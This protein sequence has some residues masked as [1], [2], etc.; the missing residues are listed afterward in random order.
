MLCKGVCVFWLWSLR[1]GHVCESSFQLKL[2]YMN[3]IEREGVKG[4]RCV[5][6]CVD[7]YVD[8]QSMSIGL[9]KRGG[10]PTSTHTRLSESSFGTCFPK[11]AKVR[12]K[13]SAG[14]S[15]CRAKPCSNSCLSLFTCPCCCGSD[16]ANMCSDSRMTAC[17]NMK[18]LI[19]TQAL[20]VLYGCQTMR[21]IWFE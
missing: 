15:S 3:D 14:G 12:A 20:P 17:S 7:L 5:C 2:T 8:A 4:C 19:T 21:C 13:A 16:C 6:V 18:I 9:G 10:D 11:K 1:V